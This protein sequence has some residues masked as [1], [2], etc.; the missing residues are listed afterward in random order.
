MPRRT[1]RRLVIDA[2]VASTCGEKNERGVRCLRFL[3]AALAVCHH[4]V[5]TH[6]IPGEW[7]THSHRSARRWRREMEGRRKVYRPDVSSNE[8]LRD[9][10]K[11][12]ATNDKERQAMLKDIH[13]IETAMAA[14]RIVVSLDET[15]RRLFITVATRVGELR[16][17]VW[18][19]PERAE[20]EPIHWLENGAKAEKKRKLG[21]AA[22]D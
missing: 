18:V 16:N 14:D 12:A 3:E 21:F 8:E 1:S 11:R 4:V 15:A 5:M 6:G 22:T 13:L 7:K 2:S 17:I 9:K 19:N 20:E 10:I